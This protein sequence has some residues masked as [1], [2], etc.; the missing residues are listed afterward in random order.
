MKNFLRILILSCI[1]ALTACKQEP[2][3]LS[4][5]EGHQFTLKD[6]RG[7]WIIVNYWASWCKPCHK[8]IPELNAFYLKHHNKDAIVLGVSYDPIKG[9]ELNELIHK[10][11]IQYPILASDPAAQLGIDSIPGLPATYII[12]PNGKLHTPL[13]GEQTVKSLEKATHTEA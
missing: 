11:G 10:I 12:D 13:F 3:S 4:D 8:E 1:V 2:A 6:Y 9:Q 7:K 5:I